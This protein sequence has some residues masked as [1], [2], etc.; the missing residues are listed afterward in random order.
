M[1]PEAQ[2]ASIATLGGPVTQYQLDMTTPIDDREVYIQD[3]HDEVL[4]DAL[5]AEECAAAKRAPK[6]KCLNEHLAEKGAIEI[7]PLAD[8]HYKVPPGDN[9]FLPAGDSHLLKLGSHYVRADLP[10]LVMGQLLWPIGKAYPVNQDWFDIC[11][12]QSSN[13]LALI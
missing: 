1:L 11:D 4:E 6:R 7:A 9:H 5:E 12:L 10:I 3:L 13:F 8:H 2:A